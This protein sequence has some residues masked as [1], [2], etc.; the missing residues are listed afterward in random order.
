M[1]METIELMQS[2]AN[3]A[4]RKI[5]SLKLSCSD[6]SA[7]EEELYQLTKVKDSTE[8]MK[9]SY[10]DIIYEAKIAIAAL[11]ATGDLIQIKIDNPYRQVEFVSFQKSA[12]ISPHLNSSF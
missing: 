8:S 6:D 9:S 12:S 3:R 11:D 1:M 10:E 4:F 2:K 5:D 7:L